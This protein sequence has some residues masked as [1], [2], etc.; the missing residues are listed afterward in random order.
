M[1]TLLFLLI[2]ILPNKP[3]AE[4]L[5]EFDGYVELNHVYSPAGRHVLDQ[6]IVWKWHE[7]FGRHHVAAFYIAENGRRR[8][9]EKEYSERVA[10]YLKSLGLKVWPEEL[11]IDNYVDR[12]D[13]VGDRRFSTKKAAGHVYFSSIKNKRIVRFKLTSFIETWTNHDRE[14]INRNFFPT[15]M[16]A[17]K[18]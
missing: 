11:D 10:A 13:W 15:E 2:G 18:Q 12:S 7:D 6:Y 3:P 5:Y 4:E 14:L 8:L 16:R 9:S 17:V 1:K